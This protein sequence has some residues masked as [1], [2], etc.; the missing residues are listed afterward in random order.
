MKK[1]LRIKTNYIS[2]WYSVGIPLI[3]FFLFFLGLP[4]TVM[5]LYHWNIPT[6][7]GI[8][9]Y[10]IGCVLGMAINVIVY[11]ALMKLANKSE[12][13]ILLEDKL[14]RWRKGLRW[15]EIDTNKPYHA[16]ISAGL[17][18]LGENNASIFFQHGEPIIHLRGAKRNELLQ[19]FPEPYFFKDIALTP[20]EGL[21]GFNMSAD[22]DSAC[23]FFYDLIKN[24]WG[25]RHH[26]KHYN[27]YCKFPWNL[28]PRPS[29]THIEVINHKEI[30]VEQRALLEELE[31]QVI[32]APSSTAKVTPDYLLGSDAKNKYFIFPLG[33]VFAEEN[34]MGDS[35]NIRYLK[36]KGLDKNGSKI[37]VK[38]PYWVH[39]TDKEYSEAMFFLRFI[40]RK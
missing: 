23:S 6:R 3:L 22:D 27:L 18:G 14:L 38:L 28:S 35:E 26:N 39:A 20:Q 1:S 11:P 31:S 17:S 16:E 24:L 12:G 4:I 25:S 37:T 7:A 13:E 21:W 36:V 34:I 15:Y 5:A 19:L 8:S 10:I 40:N 33:Y 32:S 9:L 2:G 30:T 29:F